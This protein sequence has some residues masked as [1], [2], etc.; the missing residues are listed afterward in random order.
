MTEQQ[1]LV[2]VLTDEGMTGI[3]SVFTN[4]ALVKGALGVLEPLYRGES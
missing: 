2:V 1:P 4:D 3:G